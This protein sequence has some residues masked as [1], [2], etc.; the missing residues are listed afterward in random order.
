MKSISNVA[1]N[2]NLGPLL[3]DRSFKWKIKGGN[4]CLF[5]LDW[6]YQGGILRDLFPRLFSISKVKLIS[7]N[8]MCR[9]I[10]E[11]NTNM[12]WRRHLRSWE[13]DI[14]NEICSQ[15]SQINLH[16]GRDLVFWNHTGKIYSTKDAY[17]VS[18][19]QGG[20]SFRWDF[21]WHLKLPPRILLF[22]WK[23]EHRL[24]PS[25]ELIKKRINDNIKTSCSRCRCEIESIDHILWECVS[26]R[27]VWNFI[28]EWWSI[29]YDSV[30]LNSHWFWNT[31]MSFKRKFIKHVW[32]FVGAAALWT[33]WIFRNQAVF[34]KVVGT[35]AQIL[36]I[37][38]ERIWTWLSEKDI[39][40]QSL[41]NLWSI[42]P[43]GAILLHNKGMHVRLLDSNTEELI[44]YVDGAWSQ[45]GNSMIK[46]G[47][48]GFIVDRHKNV[49]FVFSGPVKTKDASSIELEA[50]RFLF[51]EFMDS[52]YN[53]QSLVIYSDCLS[54]ISS[55][56][57]EKFS[58]GPKEYFQGLHRYSKV[59]FVYANRNL[60]QGADDLA[61][62][63]SN[64]KK[65][66]KAWC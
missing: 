15:A 25:L 53:D 18:L 49:V 16:E 34:Q 64:R 3:L 33:L 12:L 26:A 2:H 14:W 6:W 51:K 48:G 35:K 38:K 8:S 47:V 52:S 43:I 19:T 50:A 62:Q 37:V 28:C 7:V 29:P 36:A 4:E 1:L 45:P 23:V 17:K 10:R 41:A 11:D 24:L 42:N 46:A 22:F 39:I 63:G 60:I 54:V 30:I 13:F 55:F 40:S 59:S 20:S 56:F 66:L 44:G 32:G 5:W 27:W 31:T 61:K 9:L 21:I 58:Y 57:N 65:F